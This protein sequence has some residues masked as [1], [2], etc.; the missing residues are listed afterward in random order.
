MLLS[1]ESALF[2]C[3][4][5]IYAHL[6]SPSSS[7]LMQLL[8]FFPFFSP[9]SFFLP[10]Y[11]PLLLSPEIFKNHRWIN[12]RITKKREREKEKLNTEREKIAKVSIPPKSS[13]SCMCPCLDVQKCLK[14]F[15]ICINTKS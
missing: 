9:L 6:D 8:F 14:S 5:C 4:V 15:G 13:F 1:L 12:R 10:L 11:S 2:Y 7:F 3:K